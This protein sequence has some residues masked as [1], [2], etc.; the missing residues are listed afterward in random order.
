MT[1]GGIRIDNIIG[2]VIGDCVHDKPN[3]DV[4]DDTKGIEPN[5]EQEGRTPNWI[6]LDTG[7]LGMN[8]EART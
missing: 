6:R 4:G 2:E 7:P 5:K 3:N 1:H 8:H